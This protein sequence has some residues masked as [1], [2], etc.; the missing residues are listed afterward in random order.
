ME[1]RGMKEEGGEQTSRHARCVWLSLT[2]SG[3]FV[4]GRS[5]EGSRADA[6]TTAWQRRVVQHMQ[7]AASDPSARV[8]WSRSEW[9][10]L[11]ARTK[12]RTLPNE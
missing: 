12:S 10:A 2:E 9:T 3:M 11:R 6:S 4:S 5:G 8:E 1:R 7:S